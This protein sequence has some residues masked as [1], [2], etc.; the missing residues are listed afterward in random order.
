MY[1]YTIG[2]NKNEIK[3]M[4]LGRLRGD[5]KIN[6]T[7]P[8]PLRESTHF[9]Y[10]SFQ[11]NIS[12]N[13]GMQVLISEKV[14]KFTS[15]TSGAI[16]T[17]GGLGRCKPLMGNFRVFGAIISNFELFW[18]DIYCRRLSEESHRSKK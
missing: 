18:E 6:P 10:F 2:C 15:Y 1:I 8:Y 16:L 7:F 9:A 11:Y 17:A 13:P 12:Q 5:L 4:F 14:G 3:E